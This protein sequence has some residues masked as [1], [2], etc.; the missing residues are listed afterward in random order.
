MQVLV[1]IVVD[2]LILVETAV[3][4]VVVPATVVLLH[5]EGVFIQDQVI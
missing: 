3:V 2:K 1:I 5:T 4:A